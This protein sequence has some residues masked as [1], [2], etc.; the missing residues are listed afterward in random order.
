MAEDH[1]YRFDLACG[2]RIIFTDDLL[3]APMPMQQWMP[4]CTGEPARMLW[5]VDDRI[6]ELVPGLIPSIRRLDSVCDG[7]LAMAGPVHL[8]PGGER[9]KNDPAIFDQVLRQMHDASLDRMSYAVVLGGGAVLDCVGFAAAMAHRGVRLVRLPTTTLGQADSGVGVKNGINRFGKKNY[10][11]CFAV[12]WAVINDW[13]LLLSLPDRDWLS[14]FAEAVKV[15]LLK[16]AAGFEQIAESTRAIVQR[17]PSVCRPIIRRS[18]LLHAEHI[19]LS[20]DP[21][22]LSSARPLDFGHWAGHK[23]EQL[24]GFGLRHGEAVAI[25]MAIDLRYA[26]LLGLMPGDQVSRVM[27]CLHGLGLP[28]WHPAMRD[29]GELLQGIEEFREHLGGRLTITLLKQIG[30]MQNVHQIDRALMIRAIRSLSP[31][32]RQRNAV[33]H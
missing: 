3:S 4:S 5:F 25:G 1:A 20:G 33:S 23:L 12:P 32:S 11:G 30:R 27:D 29:T 13:R 28:T 2:H 24:S 7:Q 8:V 15:C 26:E 22:E 31:E 14:G 16:D 9:C 17:D 21:F 19:A 18:A 10:L 6:T